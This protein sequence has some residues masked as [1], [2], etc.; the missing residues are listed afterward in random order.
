M[1]IRESEMGLVQ[2]S[3]RCSAARFVIQ[4]IRIDVIS[5][6]LIYFWKQ[7]KRTLSIN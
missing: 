5:L 1:K 7:T 3:Q 2:V 6:I 4:G